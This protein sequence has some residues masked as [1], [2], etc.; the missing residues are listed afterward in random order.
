MS[1]TA[2]NTETGEYLKEPGFVKL[3]YEAL[4]ACEK[5]AG[6]EQATFIFL[7]SKMDSDNLVTVGKLQRMAFAEKQKTT[8]QCITNAIHSLKNK[9]LIKVASK[10]EYII[11]ARIASRTSWDNVVKIILKH[12]FSRQGVTRSVEFLEN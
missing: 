7:I 10:G 3:Y 5:I 12:E 2:L 9:G 6:L 1:R 4:A 8:V 11:N